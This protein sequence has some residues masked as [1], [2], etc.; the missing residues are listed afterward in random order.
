M[1]KISLWF[2]FVSIAC[3]LAGIALA[4]TVGAIIVGI[5]VGLAAYNKYN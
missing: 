3:M 1:E 2:V 5:S 4:S